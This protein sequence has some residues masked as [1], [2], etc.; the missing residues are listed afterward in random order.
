[1]RKIQE[2]VEV[3]VAHLPVRNY[4]KKGYALNREI[5]NEGFYS[6]LN[7]NMVYAFYEK[8]PLSNRANY[9]EIEMVPH[10]FMRDGNVAGNIRKLSEFVI[11]SLGV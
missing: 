5:D 6:R 8:T 3:Y 2:G 4:S 1:M 10:A 7:K 9:T 11:S